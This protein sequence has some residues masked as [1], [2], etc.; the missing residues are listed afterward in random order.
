MYRKYKVIISGQWNYRWFLWYSLNFFMSFKYSTRACIIHI[1][2]TYIIR[3]NA[4]FLRRK[5][6][7]NCRYAV[8]HPSD[9]YLFSAFCDGFSHP[10][11]VAIT[12]KW[13]HC[14][15]VS[16]QYNFCVFVV[17]ILSF[18]RTEAGVYLLHA[19]F[20]KLYKCCI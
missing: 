14:F 15:G 16:V 20:S 6:C 8:I 4:I 5:V 9:S 18:S 13:S 19:L 1:Y 10:W 7:G 12:Y 11:T 2:Y 3:K 17:D